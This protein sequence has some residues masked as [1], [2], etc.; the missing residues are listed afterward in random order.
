MKFLFAC[1]G[2]AGHINP[3]IAVAGRLK[4]LLP[5][6]QFLFVGAKGKM[7]EDLVPRAGYEIKLI[8]ITNIQRSLNLEGIKHNL[9]TAVNVVKSLGESKRI[10]KEFQPDV[11]I[12]TG[13]YVCFPVLKAAQTMKIPTVLHESN[14][15]PGLTTKML[16]GSVDAMMV[17]FEESVAAYKNQDIVTVT[18]TPV[19]GDF[20]TY[21]KETAKAELGIRQDEK[22]IVSV[23][24][25]L[26]ATRMN[27]IMADFI[28]DTYK[29]SDF[30][31]IHAAGRE[32]YDD[33]MEQLHSLCP[34][35]CSR[36]GYDVRPYIYDMSR[37]MAAADLV[38]CRAG[39]ST[40]A[41]LALMGKPC[42]LVPS[43]NVTNNHQ[44]KNAR[45]L[46]NAGGAVVL[47]EAGL[48][49]EQFKKTVLELIEDEKRLNT[50]AEAMKK[51]APADATERITNV[52]LNLVTR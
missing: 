35:G 6:S 14:A 32:R 49:S 37:V 36:Q 34:T 10:I 8:E 41:E 16:S 48:T 46:E 31:L 26:G 18:G 23:W 38:V 43:P 15:E 20:R 2:T 21:S 25:S 45:V 28:A 19:R 39:A 22:L 30:D 47:V 27:E 51:A 29:D 50:M 1:G 24:G 4:E 52:V 33:M 9:R 5:D 12:G 44:E 11:V 13:G 3:A 40:L 7:E 42:V 17:G